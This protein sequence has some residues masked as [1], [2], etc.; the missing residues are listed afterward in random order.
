[1]K[2]NAS[3]TD[4]TTPPPLSFHRQDIERRLCLPAGK[5][6][7]PGAVLAPLLGVAMTFAFYGVLSGTGDSWIA[8]SFTQRG[9]IPYATALFSFWALAILLVKYFKIRLQ[10]KALNYRVI[11]DNPEFVLGVSSVEKVLDRLYEIAQ[12][13]RDFLLYNRIQ[14]A[15][16]NLKNLGQVSDVD[17]IL[18]TRADNDEA[19]A[20]SSY[21]VLRGLLW[22]I[23]V[24]G[25]IGTVIGLSVAIGSFGD[26]LSQSTGIDQLKPALRMVTG[27]LSTAFETTLQ[28]LLA[29]LIIQMLM[30]M[31]KRTEEHMFDRCNDYCDRQVVGKLRLKSE[32]SQ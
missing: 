27:G 31:L 6:T 9:Y 19:A 2:K 28:A 10:K 15:L 4:S 30:T 21:T 11:P 26:V 5:Y 24:L 18:R 20:E 12:E 22:A 14:F 25:F 7:Q 29:A 17:E 13:P 3:S 8:R 1:M 32:E 16:S 23:P